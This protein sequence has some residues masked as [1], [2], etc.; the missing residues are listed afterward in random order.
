MGLSTLNLFKI[1]LIMMLFYSTCINLL[2]YSMPED[3][4][5]YITSYSELSGTIS[6][7]GVSAEVQ[8]SVSRQ[9]DIPVIELGALVFYSGNIL[10]DLI[11]NFAFAIPE[12][13]SLVIN[14][15]LTI[16]NIDSQINNLI[17]LFTTVTI[18]VMYF[19]G[20]ITLLTSVR[21]GRVL[22]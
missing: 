1:T 7:E 15:I 18:T 11:L 9:T 4:I 20:V 2:V 17:Q 13:L 16:L 3:T 22:G 10:I 14:G 8:T 5:P 19:I 21:S 12:M 6:L